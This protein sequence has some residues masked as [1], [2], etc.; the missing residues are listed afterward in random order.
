M[1]A[2]GEAWSLYVQECQIHSPER[3]RPGSSPEK[4]QSLICAASKYPWRRIFQQL[5]KGRKM[6]K[7]LRLNSIRAS[8]SIQDDV[9]CV[10]EKKKPN[11]KETHHA[12]HTDPRQ[13]ENIKTARDAQGA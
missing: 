1:C 10:R 4:L 7:T 3:P 9:E 8:I 13:I 11:P 5:K 12:I 6:G 2:G